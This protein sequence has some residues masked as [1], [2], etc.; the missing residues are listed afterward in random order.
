MGF[1]KQSNAMYASITNGKFTIRISQPTSDS[2]Q[3]TTKDG[4]VVNE[5]TY[6]SVTGRIVAID[7]R[8]HQEYGKFWNVT[9]DDGE[10]TAIIQF[11]YSSGYA[12]AF[13]KQL[14]NVD[15]NAPVKLVPKLTET[16]GKKKTTLFIN[17]FG[18][19]LKH[20][21]T[22]DHPNGLPQLEQIKV[23]GVVTWDDT[24]MME[25]FEKYV[26]ENIQPKLSKK[27]ETL[28]DEL[29]NADEEMPF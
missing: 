17:Q 20:Y 25:F 5:E 22:K 27:A 1:E 4:K 8:E 9:V 2:V 26:K 11:K 16:N 6:D 10:N 28:V 19:A 29:A 23:K 21:F 18:S 13:L 24:K 14:P 12:S 15:F 3:R 7:I